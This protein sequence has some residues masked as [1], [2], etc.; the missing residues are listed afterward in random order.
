[1]RQT[2]IH[3][4]QIHRLCSFAICPSILTLS[5]VQKYESYMRSQEIER[6]WA[7]VET[8]LYRTANGTWLR[9]DR[10]YMGSACRTKPLM[11]I[12]SLFWSGRRREKKKKEHIVVSVIS[13][14]D[15]TGDGI[16]RSWVH[17]YRYTSD[18]CIRIVYLCAAGVVWARMPGKSDERT[19]RDWF[20]FNEPGVKIAKQEYRE[21]QSMPTLLKI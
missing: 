1:M 5:F 20:H 8:W 16:V 13:L 12:R 11:G 14:W 7:M 2:G 19:S 6:M 4:E 15:Q 10:W 9:G 21:H 18:L 17:V 3:N